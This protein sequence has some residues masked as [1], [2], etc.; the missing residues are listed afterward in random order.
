MAEGYGPSYGMGSQSGSLAGQFNNYGLNWLNG[1]GGVTDG[2]GGGFG[3][4][5]AGMMNQPGV[6][7]GGWND[8]SMYGKV[9]VVSEGLS[10]FSNLANI[11]AGFKALKLQK[12]Q[13]KFQKDAW[14]KNYN[15]QVKDYENNLKDRWAA[16]SNS[17]AARGGT[18]ESMASYVGGRALTGQAPSGG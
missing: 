5:Y 3:P 10:A 7:G 16:R 2:T 4:N 6:G 9:G 13:F 1:G 17:A 14:N 18:Y 11:Y 8:L 12:D 15:N